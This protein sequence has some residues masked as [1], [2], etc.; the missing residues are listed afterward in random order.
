MER[1]ESAKTS[2]DTK[3][4]KTEKTKRIDSM[5]ANLLLDDGTITDLQFR[6][7]EFMIQLGQPTSAKKIAIGL[8]IIGPE[9]GKGNNPGT[10]VVAANILAINRKLSNPSNSLNI[11]DIAKTAEKPPRYYIP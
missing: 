11:M 2:V 8:G 6:I 5:T 3:D 1:L 10:E 9:R 4:G 7:L